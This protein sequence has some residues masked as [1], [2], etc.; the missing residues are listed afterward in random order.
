MLFQQEIDNMVGRQK[1]NIVS[2]KKKIKGNLYKHMITCN[3]RCP[4]MMDI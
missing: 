2:R 3:E 1:T 4:K